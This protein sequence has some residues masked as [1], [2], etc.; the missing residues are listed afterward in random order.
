MSVVSVCPLNKQTGLTTDEIF[1]IQSK[2]LAYMR[3]SSCSTD[4]KCAVAFSV[5]STIK[6]CLKKY[7]AWLLASKECKTKAIQ[8][9]FVA[10]Q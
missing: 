10:V 4:I 1:C 5:T 2:F 8:Q 7:A 6:C 3:G 9:V